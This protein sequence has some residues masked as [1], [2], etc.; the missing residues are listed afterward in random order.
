VAACVTAVLLALRMIGTAL[1]PLRSLARQ[2]EEIG[3]GHWMHRIEVNRNDEIGALAAS[4]NN[5]AEKL[6]EAW[7]LE[8][9]RLHR[10][11]VMSDA[12]L[13]NLYD[14]VIVTDGDGKVVHWNRA[15]SGLFGPEEPALGRPIAAAVGEQR[16]A[17]AISNAIHQEQVSAHEGEAGEVGLAVGEGKRTYRLRATPMADDNGGLLGAVAVLEDITHL[18]E[19]DRL[20]TEFIGVA[21]HEMKTPVT[22]MLLFVQLLQ[23]GAGGPLTAQQTELVTAL[24]A[25]LERLER[26]MRD[27]LDIARLEA[28]VTPPRF[29][30][31]PPRRLATAACD[32]TA[33]LAEAKNVALIN[34][35]SPDLPLIRAD[36]SQLTRVLV[37]LINNGV[38][39]TPA[40]GSITVAAEL[41]KASPLIWFR[42][43]DTGEGIPKEYL[44]RIF[45]RFVQVPGATGHGS[46]LGLSIAKTI[47]TAHGGS[48]SAESELGHGTT[49]T[50]SIPIAPMPDPGRNRTESDATHLS[51]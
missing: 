43:T 27:L 29:E 50:F 31:L 18:R 47:V 51:N 10:A 7:E 32:A 20:K 16:I 42:V 24:R 13:E 3:A 23:E 38:R 4:F 11:E 36:L 39:H 48:I 34:N 46:G 9:Q 1:R 35:V 26:M 6:R 5:M 28:G 15:A 33:S 19:L 8:E 49:V 17:E 14:P 12:A 41:D 45:E 37:N 30:I 2:A 44:E 21:S 22:S 25:D 40:G